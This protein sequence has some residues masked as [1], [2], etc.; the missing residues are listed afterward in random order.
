MLLRAYESLDENGLA[1]VKRRRELMNEM[2]SELKKYNLLPEGL[3]DSS[4]M[5]EY[6]H[7]IIIN[8]ASTLKTKLNL[9]IGEALKYKSF[10]LEK[11]RFGSALPYIT[12][13]VASDF[14]YL[15][16]AKAL[17]ESTKL[18]DHLRINIDRSKYVEQ[19]KEKNGYKNM[20]TLEYISR[21]GATDPITNDKLYV[22]DLHKLKKLSLEEEQL[23][24][25]MLNYLPEIL[26]NLNRK[27]VIDFYTALRDSLK[28]ATDEEKSY[29]IIPERYYKI[30]SKFADIKKE[31]EIG[32]KIKKGMNFYRK[33]HTFFPLKVLK[34]QFNNMI[35]DIEVSMIYPELL[36]EI[37]Q[38]TKDMW[39]R[40][41]TKNKLPEELEK[42][43]IELGFSGTIG[44]SFFNQELN[45]F[46]LYRFQRL[47]FGE[48]LGKDEPKA[49]KLLASLADNYRNIF[50]FREGV[51]RLAA[52][53]FFKKKL[54]EGKLYYAASHPE[55]INV[56]KNS[57]DFGI[58]QAAQILARELI[59][60]YGSLSQGGKFL[61][62]HLIPFWSFTEVNF[63]RHLNLLRN[64]FADKV[65]L[66]SGKIAPDK[67]SFVRRALAFTVLSAAVSTFNTLFFNEEQQVLEKLDP[68]NKY[69]IIGKDND[70]NDIFVVPIQSVVEDFGEWL[71]LD[72]PSV[73]VD[74]YKGLFNGD[75][76]IESALKKVISK[77]VTKLFSGIGLVKIPFELWAGKTIFPD[78]YK[79]KPI[80][81]N[82]EYV[83]EQLGL[84]PI[85]K[86]VTEPKGK[87][88]S[89][90]MG[91]TLPLKEMNKDELAYYSSVRKAFEFLEYKGYEI[92][93]V[94]LT[95]KMILLRKYRN[96]IKAGD[97]ELAQK[98]KE[99]FLVKGGNEKNITTALKKLNP[100]SF[101]PIKYRSEFFNFLTEEEKILLN[102]GIKYWQEKILENRV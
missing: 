88:L 90:A 51:L 99:E 58:N 14:S 27:E 92:P 59:G 29:I 8:E 54:Q 40:Y 3:S 41:M 81:S 102:K 60:D 61:R 48:D 5:F 35:G 65:I 13:M 94:E 100:I 75:M 1:L 26:G 10:G 52:Y 32:L 80:Y 57:P 62:D 64:L 30:L 70:T 95:N 49:K 72:N 28:T 38:A 9:G 6:F 96:A 74:A 19:L 37:K 17:I 43:L 56:L 91:R 84:D 89:T 101:I 11:E 71:N 39:L 67:F 24:A 98:I 2:L 45:S 73:Y 50:M 16:Q 78:V 25:A 77:P 20:S 12:N 4:D 15:L 44:S 33:A 46:G 21:F 42:E 97:T 23:E 36:K 87:K 76:S 34:W 47:L 79:G 31:S 22:Y 63:K 53:R 82:M 85:F 66:P 69:L 55:V 83:S 7:R 68:D 86:L 18:I 93:K